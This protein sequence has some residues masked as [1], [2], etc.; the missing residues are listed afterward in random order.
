MVGEPE[1]VL[2]MAEGEV[3]ALKKTLCNQCRTIK[4]LYTELEEER[5]ASATAAEEALSMILRL[6]EEKASEKLE[7]YQYKRLTDEKMHHAEESLA[8]LE[9]ALFQKEIEIASLKYQ[10]QAYKHKFLRTSVSNPDVGEMKI[11]D[12]PISKRSSAFLD[13]RNFPGFVRRNMSMPA[14][15]LDQLCLELNII[16]EDDYLFHRG[17]SIQRRVD[18]CTNQLSEEYVESQRENLPEEHVIEACYCHREQA[19]KLDIRMR[20]LLYTRNNKEKV[21]FESISVNN[22]LQKTV[23]KG[24]VSLGEE[25]KSCSWYSAVNCD[26]LYD[27]TV[28]GIG[29]KLNDEGVSYM[30]SQ[31]EEPENMSE[32]DA[33]CSSCLKTELNGKTPHSISVQDIEV[34]ES[35]SCSIF[36]ESYKQVLQKPISESKDMRMPHSMPQEAINKALLHTGG[37]NGL[38]TS[39]EG[40]S[41]NHHLVAVDPEIAIAPSETEIEQ[42]KKWMEQLEND[43]RIMRQE[44]SNGGRVQLKLLREIRHQLNTIQSDIKNSKSKKCPP[45][46]DSSLVFLMEAMLS[47]WL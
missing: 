39:R 3:A 28:G 18:D 34:L 40:A 32:C 46:D 37:G 15:H 42:L 12:Y 11:F 47:F 43:T 8:I 31:V 24:S 35:H 7:A 16:D 23:A 6:Q 26:A 33:L 13:K 21:S 29:I 17:Q 25:C 38:S 10:I 41:V 19:E 45:Q 9:E 22:E 2:A 5:K 20:E 36:S 30:H 27:S 1:R 4:K 14:A 44:Y